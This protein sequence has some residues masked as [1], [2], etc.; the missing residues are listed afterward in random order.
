MEQYLHDDLHRAIG[1]EEDV[2]RFE[3]LVKGVP[4]VEGAGA[5]NDATNDFNDAFN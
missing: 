4:A 1:I 3:V 2:S 5:G